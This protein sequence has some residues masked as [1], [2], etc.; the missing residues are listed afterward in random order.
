MA[1]ARATGPCYV[2]S[3]LGN[4]RVTVSNYCGAVTSNPAALTIAPS[5]TG[6]G[7][8]NGSLE[9][10]DIRGLLEVNPADAWAWRQ[11]RPEGY[12]AS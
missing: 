3:E 7:N 2:T 8:G 4:Y 9:G 11:A 10:R 6:D 5:G 12:N 1:I